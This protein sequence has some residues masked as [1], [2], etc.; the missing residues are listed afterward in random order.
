M[1]RRATA[2]DAR[3]ICDIYNHYIEQTVITFE[4]EPLPAEEMERRIAATA[5]SL[6]WL[7]YEEGGRV[8]GYA[9]AGRW[10]DRS[11]YRYTVE[12]TVYVDAGAAGRGIGAALYG[13][14]LQELR[15]LGV[16]AVIGGI[17]LPN[18]GSRRL[19]EK[20]GFMKSGHLS[21]VGYKFGRWIDVG[22][23]ELVF[24]ERP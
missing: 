16:H 4:E 2:A 7:V 18:E 12:S 23:W 19:H 21:Q 1:I 24:D 3:R 14:L 20:M 10:R 6:P 15:R 8:L 5:P 11:A 9:Y 13:E 22:Y 17:S